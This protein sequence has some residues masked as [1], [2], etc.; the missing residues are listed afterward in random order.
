[1]A[2][3][4]YA[5][6]DAVFIWHRK[7]EITWFI[8][9]QESRTMYRFL[10]G[11]AYSRRGAERV[12]RRFQRKILAARQHARRLDKL[13]PPEIVIRSVGAHDD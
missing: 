2:D 8:G 4:F 6:F 11:T 13:P 5:D 3:P 12:A 1:M 9:Y 10:D 7:G